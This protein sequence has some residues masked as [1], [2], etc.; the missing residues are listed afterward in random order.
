MMSRTCG[1]VVVLIGLSAALAGA[2][3]PGPTEVQAATNFHFMCTACKAEWVTDAEGAKATFGGLP[4]YAVRVACR[5]CGQ[6]QA[7]LA[8][9]CPYCHKPYVSTIH[10]TGAGYASLRSDICPHCGKD[11]LKWRRTP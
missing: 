10:Q 6:K 7:F 8:A 11:I 1:L 2:R 4:N 5:Q 3:G 9:I